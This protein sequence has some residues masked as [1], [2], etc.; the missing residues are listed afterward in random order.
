M[1]GALALF[2][3]DIADPSNQIGWLMPNTRV[4]LLGVSAFGFA[5]GVAGTYLVLRRRA[6]AGDVI[7]HAALPG[8]AI[9]FLIWSGLYPESNKSL[10]AL[11]AGGMVASAVG[12]VSMATLRRFSN[13]PEDAILAIVLSTFFALG[14][15]LL[16]IIQ[17]VPSGS[18]G[19]IR[20][21]IFGQAATIRPQE[22]YW[23]TATAGIV[24]A[25]CFCLMKQWTLLCF[26]EAACQV[27]GFSRLL[28][29]LLMFTAVLLVCVAG[30]QAVGLLL[31]VALLVIPPT[32]A[33]FWTDHV[34]VMTL[35]AGMLGALAALLGGIASATYAKL[36]T[37]PVIV[38]SAAGLMGISML[39]GF[40]H[41]WLV[42]RR[43]RR[44]RPISDPMVQK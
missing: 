36:P 34:R 41:G 12:M 13:L 38:V 40:R 4:A 1:A 25:S 14:V 44:Y 30:M 32:A 39:V 43:R 24:T 27:M 35:I 31:V 3:T 16:S 33:R 23:M 29:D 19:G 18:Q 28:I 10:P 2:T 42:G 15:V 9:A 5:A 6:L 37:G 26:D 11:L 17:Q 20:D 22:A 7:G 21:F 8:V